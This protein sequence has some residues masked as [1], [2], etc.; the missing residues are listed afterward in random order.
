VTVFA[1]FRPADAAWHG[2]GGDAWVTSWSASPQVGTPD[3]LAAVGFDDQTVRDIICSSV[4][5]SRIRLELT[6]QFGTSPLRVGDMTVAVAG[7]GAAVAPGSIHRV[8]LDGRA[9]F[10][11]P[12]G[13]QVLSDPLAMSVAPLQD[14]AVSVYLPDQTRAATFHLNSQQVNWISAPGDHAADAD[15]GAFPSAVQS[16][17][18]VSALIVHSP[19]VYGTVVTF[20]DSIT[21]GVQSTIGGNARWPNDL[22]RRLDA[23]NGP[24]LAV[25]DEGIGGNRLLG[26]SGCCGASA[27]ARFAR[28]ALDQPGGIDRPVLRPAAHPRRA[29]ALRKLA[30]PKRSTSA[31]SVATMVP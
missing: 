29:R 23:V 19:G 15:A 25:A 20:G 22:A 18:Y 3:T 16:W 8:R 9:S 1:D 13:A 21:D 6:N 17:Y 28:D 14:L 24:T 10:E 7:P 27:E 12:A 5:G 30:V 31:A 4:G 26:G 11:I 2:S